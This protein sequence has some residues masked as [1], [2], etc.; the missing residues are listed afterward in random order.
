MSKI[1]QNCLVLMPAQCLA[2]MA[3]HNGDWLPA[4]H[5]DDHIDPADLQPLRPPEV[6]GLHV[7]VVVPMEDI[8]EFATDRD[9]FTGEESFVECKVNLWNSPSKDIESVKVLKDGKEVEVA[10]K[11]QISNAFAARPIKVHVDEVRYKY[12][13]DFLKDKHVVRITGAGDPDNFAGWTEDQVQKIVDVVL[14]DVQ[15]NFQ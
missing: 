1:L 15:E 11:G 7:V 8:K 9:A 14:K 4:D 6:P 10:R 12:V 5:N 2:L 13:P 3:D